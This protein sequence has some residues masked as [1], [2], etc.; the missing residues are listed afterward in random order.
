MT[1]DRYMK[2]FILKRLEGVEYRIFIDLVET[3][4]LDESLNKKI[5]ADC[6]KLEK[7]MATHKIHDLRMR[8]NRL[9]EIH[10]IKENIKLKENLKGQYIEEF[11]LKGVYQLG[12]SKGK[13]IFQIPVESFPTHITNCYVIVDNSI[14]TLI[15][16]GSGTAFARDDLTAGLK[17]V[18]KYYKEEVAVESLDYLLITHGHIDHFGMVN[19]L[20]ETSPAK[21]MIHELDA[22][23]LSRFDEKFG[24]TSRKVED[25]LARSGVGSSVSQELHEMYNSSK[26]FFNPTEVNITMKDGDKVINGYEVI[27]TP[28]HCPGQICLKVDDVLFTGDHVL[29]SISPHQAPESLTPNMGLKHYLASLEKVKNIDGLELILP[30]HQDRIHDLPRR[31][32]HLIAHHHSRFYE[33][34]DACVKPKNLWEITT[35]LLG[36]LEGYNRL[37]ALEE[38]A[39]HIEYLAADGKIEIIDDKNGG[40]S[41]KP[42]LYKAHIE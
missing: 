38:I 28:G 20:Q 30:G 35:T 32:R 29:S 9:R 11:G 16:P 23:V 14:S 5:K 42:I 1:I 7:D 22:N 12:T 39:A 26:Y 8:L 27:H 15:D 40:N 24:N 2:K 17:V 4:A 21:I 13:K 37:L 19:F 25:F 36:T 10:Q 33:V 18:R 34:L 31:V 6:D 41:D 3:D